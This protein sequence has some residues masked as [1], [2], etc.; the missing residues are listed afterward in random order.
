ML[1]KVRG[2]TLLPFLF[3]CGGMSLLPSQFSHRLSPY[4]FHL[5]LEKGVTDRSSNG[6]P[7]LAWM[8]GMLLAP[9]DPFQCISEFLGFKPS[10]LPTKILLS[11]LFP[12]GILMSMQNFLHV[13]GKETYW[14]CAKI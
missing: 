14:S 4:C 3:V 13:F 11:R 1:P 7:P 2:Q 10:E 9:K 5:L 8:E 6:E 12:R